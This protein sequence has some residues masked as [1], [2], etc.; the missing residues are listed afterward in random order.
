MSMPLLAY[1]RRIEGRLMPACS[2][3]SLSTEGQIRF[4]TIVWPRAEAKV[5]NWGLLIRT[6]NL[7]MLTFL[8]WCSS[9]RIGDRDS[10]SD[11]LLVIKSRMDQNPGW[12]W[13][14]LFNVHASWLRRA[15][16]VCS[17]LRS[18]CHVG[19]SGCMSKSRAQSELVKFCSDWMGS[20]ES[21]VRI[22]CQSSLRRLDT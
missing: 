12:S 16:H 14:S 11:K 22:K 20:D 6:S 4:G 13:A 17:V 15:C 2:W 5:S 19:Q 3:V 10:E 7:I 21:A 1:R 9:K 8:C 18:F